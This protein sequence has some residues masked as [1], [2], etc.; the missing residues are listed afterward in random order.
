MINQ[1]YHRK[2]KLHYKSVPRLCEY[3]R[4]PWINLSGFW[5]EKAGFEIG[6]NIAISVTKETLIIKIENKAPRVK[7]PWED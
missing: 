3:K 2:A 6:D 5:L 4:V 7:A 1:Q